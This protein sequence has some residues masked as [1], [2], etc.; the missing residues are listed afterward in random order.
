MLLPSVLI[1]RSR[2]RGFCTDM[3]RW[4]GTVERAVHAKGVVKVPKC[5]QVPH[6]IGY[7]PE[8]D[9]VEIFSANGADQPFDERMRNGRVRNRLDLLD[10]EY[11]QVGEPAVESKQRI[12]VGHQ[13]LRRRLAACDLRSSI[14]EPGSAS[15][16]CIPG[17]CVYSAI[18]VCGA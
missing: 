12:V 15:G 3:L 9:A 7:V 11:A 10:L 17:R 1:K 6:Q 8:E 13:V 4:R 18:G 16:S 2:S 5:L 14:S